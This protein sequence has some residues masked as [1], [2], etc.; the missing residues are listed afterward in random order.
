MPPC[1]SFQSIMAL[2]ILDAAIVKAHQHSVGA[3]K[4]AFQ[5]NR[6]QPWR[7]RHQNPGSSGCLW[8]SRIYHA[9]RRLQKLSKNILITMEEIRGLGIEDLDRMFMEK[10]LE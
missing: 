7:G 1:V 10:Y 8:V 5:G 3:K 9:E 6:T 4:E 2:G